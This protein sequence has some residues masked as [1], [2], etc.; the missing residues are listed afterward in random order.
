MEALMKALMMIITVAAFFFLLYF[1][2][3][4]GYEHPF[5][6]KC[7]HSLCCKRNESG[8]IICDI[9]KNVTNENIITRI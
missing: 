9:H 6:P 7:G 5:C 2:Y 8:E 4:D 1:V 3:R